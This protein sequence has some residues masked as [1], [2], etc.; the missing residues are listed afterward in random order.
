MR[1]RVWEGWDRGWVGDERGCGR[2]GI[3]VGGSVGFPLFIFFVIAMDV[4]TSIVSK[5]QEM[6]VLSTMPGCTSMQRISIYADDVVLFIKPTLADLSFVVEMLRIFGEASGLKVNFAKSSAIL[7]RSSKEDEALVRSMVPWQ[8]AKFPCKYLGLQLS[9][10]QLTRSDW[11]P[12]VDVALKILPGWQRG[13]VTRPGR[14]ILVNQVMRARPT[15]HLLVAEAPKWALKK[16]DSG[17]RAF[18]WAGSEKIHGGKCA[19]AWQRVCRL[20]QMG[21]LGVID[22]HRHGIALRMRWEWL[23]RYD[24][25]RPW[26]GLMATVDKAA[27]AAFSSMVH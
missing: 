24:E 18:F 6:G 8:I 27:S 7:I 21:G 1:V 16:V 25:N 22:L 17:C 5:G 9:I 10:K 4:L 14:L 11:Q 19:V 23:K 12:I 3:G 2:D 13:L 20:K 26:Q 15:H